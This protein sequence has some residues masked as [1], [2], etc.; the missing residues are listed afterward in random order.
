MKGTTHM[1]IGVA[2]F[3]SFSTHADIE[4]GA[5]IAGLALAALG[6]V[7]PDID[8]PQSFISRRLPL[9]LWLVIPHRGITHSLLA[10]LIW[11]PLSMVHWSLG[12]IGLGYVLHI[13]ADLVTKN[14]TSLYA[15]FSRVRVGLLPRWLAIRTGGLS[16]GIIAAISL[17]LLVYSIAKFTEGFI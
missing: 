11:I 3:S 2:A 8:H 7:L 16:E 6:S 9:P 14:G 17:I 1:L 13:A 10:V 15:P 5:F 4:P 12:I